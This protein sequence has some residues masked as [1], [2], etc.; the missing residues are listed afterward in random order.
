MAGYARQS[1]SSIADGEVITAAPLNSEFD[2]ILAA[3]AFS[4][5]HNHDGSS[6]EG[7]YVGLIADVDALNKVVVDTANNRHGFFVEVSSSAVEQ[8]RIQDG[9]IVPV[10]DSDIDLGTSSLEF[11]DLYIDGTAYIDTLEVHEG[12]T[13][14]A[15]V[16]SLPD[17]SASAPVITNTGDTNQGLYFSGTDEMSFTAGGTGQVTFADGVI[18]P[19]TDNDIDLGTSSNQFK[20]LHIN[21]TANIDALAGTTMS[22]NLAMGSNSI[23]GLAAPS[24]DGDAAR[25]VYVD[26]SIASAEGLTQLAGNINVNGYYFYGSS[27]EDVKFQPQTGASVLSTQDTDGEFVALVLRNE[28]DASDTTGIASLRFD[29]EDTG[30]N[31]V[32]AAKIAVKKEQTF[33]A[34]ASSQDSKIVFSTSLNGTLTEYLELSSAGALVPVTNNTVD[35]GTSSKQIKDMYVDGTAYIDAIGFGTTSVT[36][37]TS[38]GSA[39]QI[40]KTNGSGTISWANDTGTTINNAT[41]NE[42]VT[43]SST[44]TQLDGE[45]NLTFDGTTLTLNGKLAMASNTAGKLLIAD[46]TDFEPTAVTDLSEISTVASD[47]VLMAIDASGGGLKKITRSNLVSGLATSSAISNVSEDSTPQLGGDLDAQGKDITD[48]GIL[49]ADASAGI[50]GPTGSPVVFTVTVASKTAAHP[51]YSDGSSS[52][53]F[54]NGV[55]SPAIKLHGADSVTSSTEYFYKFDQADSSN[56]GHPLRFYL[57]AAKSIAYTTGVTTSGTPG[58]AGAHTTIAVTDQTP[59]TLYYQC[60]SHGYMGNYASVDSANITSSGAVTID[61]VGDVT[62]DA[63]GGDIVFKDAGTTFGSAT[64][65][66]GNLILKSGT[67]TALTFSGANATAAGNIIVTGDLTVNG[68]TTTVNSTTVTI[69]DPIFTLGGDSAPGS[70]DNK[71]RGIEFR[72]HNGSDAKVGFF[73]YDDSASAFT[74]IPDATNSSEVFSGTAGNVVFGNITGTLQTAAQTN[75][76]S[77]GALDG[78]S[79]TSGFGAID[80]GTSGIRTNTFTAETSVVPDASGGADLGSTSLEWGDLYIA[81]DKKIYLGSDQDVSIEYDEDGN[82]TTAIVAANGISFAPHGSSAGNGTELR[83]QELAANGANY[84]GFKAPDAISSNEV[85]VLP[86]ADGSDGQVLKTDGSNALAW[87][88]QASGGVESLVADGAITAGKPVILTS[89]GKAK[90]VALEG[91]T[92]AAVTGVTDVDTG[93]TTYGKAVDPATGTIMVCYHDNSNSNRVTVRAGSIS[94]VDYT[95]GSEVVIS[96]NSNSSGVAIWWDSY[97]SAFVVAARADSNN[98]DLVVKSMTVSGNTITVVDTATKTDTMLGGSSANLDN[99]RAVFDST[100]NVGILVM[101]S[102][103]DSGNTSFIAISLSS[104]RAVTIGDQTLSTTRFYKTS[105]Q[106]DLAHDTSSGYTALFSYYVSGSSDTSAV[107]VTPLSVSG[108]TIT[109]GTTVEIDSSA[110]TGGVSVADPVAGK[111]AYF[112]EQSSTI[113]YNVITISSSGGVTVGTKGTVGS[114]RE[115]SNTGEWESAAYSTYTGKVVIAYRNSS[116]YLAF[117]RSGKISGDTITFDTEQ[118]INGSNNGNKYFNVSETLSTSSNVAVFFLDGS[119]G[120][121]EQ[122]YTVPFVG[123]TNLTSTN[124]LGIAA[125]TISDT[126]TGKITI[127]GGVNANQSSLTIGAA[128]FTSGAGAVGTS[129]IQF[130]GRAISATQLQVAKNQL[131]GDGSNIDNAPGSLSIDMTIASDSDSIAIGDL[132]TK[133][134]SGETKKVKKTTTTTNYDFAAVSAIQSAGS[135]IN[136]GTT[137]QPDAGGRNMAIGGSTD[138]RFLCIYNSYWQISYA[139]QYTAFVHTGSGSWTTTGRGSIGIGASYKCQPRMR[140][141]SNLNEDAGG[142]FLAA[143]MTPNGWRHS[144]FT[145]TSSGTVTLQTVSGSNYWYAPNDS[146]ASLSSNWGGDTTLYDTST[147]DATEMLGCNRVSSNLYINRW[148]LSWSGSAYSTASVYRTS[149]SGYTS[150]SSHALKFTR[151]AWDHTNNVGIVFCLGSSSELTASKFTLGNS[152]ASR[153][154][155]PTSI[156]SGTN[157]INDNPRAALSCDGHGQVFFAMQTENHGNSYYKKVGVYNTTGDSASSSYWVN[158]ISGSSSSGSAAN[159]SG[160]PPMVYD[161]LNKKLFLVTQSSLYTYSNYNWK[162]RYGINNTIRQYTFT[163]TTQDSVTEVSNSGGYDASSDSAYTYAGMWA[164]PDTQSVT[165]VTDAKGGYWMGIYIDDDDGGSWDTGAELKTGVLPH[166]LTTSSTNKSD[167]YGVAETAGAVGNSIKVI[168]KDS[169]GIIHNRSGLSSGTNYYV[170]DTGTIVSTTT[171]GTDISNNVDNPLIGQAISK[172]DIRFP[173]VNIGSSNPKILCGSYDFRVDGSSTAQN[174]TISLPSDYTASN[175]RAYEIEYYGIGFAEDGDQFTFKPYN[176]TSSVLSGNS[177]RLNYWSAYYGTSRNANSKDVTAGLTVQ[178]GYLSGDNEDAYSGNDVDNPKQN[179]DNNS[180][181]GGQL[182]GRAV[183]INSLKN[184][185]Y[186]Y[187]SS[188]RFGS[189]NTKQIIAHGV[190]SADTDNATTNYADGFYF[191]VGND[192]QSEQSVAIMEG[193]VVVYAIIG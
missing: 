163:G 153:T 164:I 132:V 130:I 29:L 135:G 162:T 181:H 188:W 4:G 191:Y 122:V 92:S 17:G 103:D 13:L 1:S 15:G 120:L 157:S 147:D 179:Y 22:G 79:I 54:L 82:D 44:T 146:S 31:T 101:S 166:S 30:G 26:D 150:T 141:I 64:N 57:D 107:Q 126:A 93:A 28:S 134:A 159:A 165:A 167:F 143:F 137:Y 127:P 19:V 47:D 129:G 67:T 11:K 139:Y 111:V 112:Y 71:D 123:N 16:V 172:T 74:F 174:V 42:L 35:I 154:Y 161:F 117:V 40:L 152:A 114:T 81:D 140:W 142:T 145:I 32:D 175:V 73:G 61:A 3:F 177:I 189:Q 155:G 193:V 24:A 169:E 52:G 80:N 50:Y 115:F 144:I 168:G 10:T 88:D 96:T 184:G 95:W 151:L 20:D 41:E 118:S 53:Y 108:T 63:D 149:F 170:S 5:G 2:A 56:S 58:N 178:R 68:T 89:T 62:L 116:S 27:G 190:G 14:S 119:T 21:G 43:V 131:T 138:G 18:K 83:F 36:L 94:G 136:P 60:S 109:V 49:S 8:L 90:Q 85:W 99:L 171:G 9:A 158:I 100:N 98:H 72:W 86:N 55:E 77:V 23:T 7:A 104:G 180:G 121:H 106:G 48:V 176:G 75:I 65:T 192:S 91:A 76:T 124:F 173:S 84:V 183:Y 51:Y 128:Y 45:S 69:D 59:S 34:T 187:S 185:S 33:T 113:Y 87:V 97:R 102:G 186:S 105:G 25:K 46:G 12:V 156:Y 78:G 70:D 160:V 37:P 182:N 6:T 110:M 39:N 66:S 125:E 148:T 38:D 133:E